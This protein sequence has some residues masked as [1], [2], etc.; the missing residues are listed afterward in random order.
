MSFYE[1]TWCWWWS[2]DCTSKPSLS[3]VVVVVEFGWWR[4]RTKAFDGD[5]WLEA[6]E[7]PLSRI[8]CPMIPSN[9]LAHRVWEFSTSKPIWIM[10]IP[11]L[12]E[13]WHEEVEVVGSL[14]I[15]WIEDSLIDN[16]GDKWNQHKK[17]RHSPDPQHRLTTLYHGAPDPNIWQI[18]SKLL[19]STAGFRS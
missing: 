2:W 18:P 1:D 16:H 12:Q 6:D 10:N 3:G 14:R 7:F 15:A 4:I 19:W 5:S 13:I 9:R 17:Q 11:A 8:L